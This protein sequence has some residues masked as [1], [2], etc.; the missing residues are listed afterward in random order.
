MTSIHTAIMQCPKDF[1]TTDVLNEELAHRLEEKKAYEAEGKSFKA[2]SLKSNFAHRVEATLLAG[3]SMAGAY[4]YPSFTAENF[5]P[6]VASVGVYLIRFYIGGKTEYFPV[7]VCMDETGVTAKAYGCNDWLDIHTFQTQMAVGKMFQSI[8]QD[9]AAI[10]SWVF[11]NLFLE[12]KQPTLFCFDVGNLRGQG[13]DFLQNKRWQKHALA[14][15]TGERLTSIPLHKYPYIRVASIITPSTSQVPLYR[16]LSESGELAG[17]TGGTFYPS[18]QGSEC[19]YYYLSN[20]RPTSRSGGILQESKL[21]SIVK[22]DGQN[23]KRAKKPKPHAQGYNPR[24]VFLNLTLQE[25][26]CFSDWASFVQGL[27]LYG[28]IHYLDTTILPAPLHLAAGLDSYRPIH[29]I[30]EP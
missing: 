7:A 26:D 29:A 4:V 20:Q 16:A 13:L 5:P 18:S 27:R 2:P 17:H 22:T 23:T 30:S 9:K 6:N 21:V 24:G 28:L 10:Q 8:R 14:F 1:L 25:D 11:N 12:V 15:N 19:G 3:L